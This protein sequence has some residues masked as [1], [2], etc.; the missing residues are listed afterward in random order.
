MRRQ[1][2]WFNFFKVSDSKNLPKEN[3]TL[4]LSQLDHLNALT[5]SVKNALSL[6]HLDKV[7]QCVNAVIRFGFD[8]LFEHGNKRL[9]QE[10]FRDDHF[11]QLAHI[12]LKNKLIT[13]VH[14]NALLQIQ[15]NDFPVLVS[16]FNCLDKQGA[17]RSDILDK[18]IML[19]SSALRH[20]ANTLLLLDSRL[21]TVSNVDR[22][23]RL[24]WLFTD[25]ANEAIWL[26]TGGLEADEF[27]EILNRVE[28]AEAANRTPSML[29]FCDENGAVYP[30]F[31]YFEKPRLTSAGKNAELLPD[32][33][34]VPAEL[35][36][37]L[38]CSIMTDPVR[39]KGQPSQHVFE[40]TWVMNW[41]LRNHTNPMTK[42][43]VPK[44]VELEPAA[45][46]LSKINVFMDEQVASQFS[47]SPSIRNDCV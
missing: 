35:T 46:I 34:D 22:L 6:L 18:V 1:F 32:S 38:S 10:R 30:S 41:I 42:L 12:L 36:C 8:G 21:V 29:D 16:I 14:V 20:F 37:P 7:D 2:S 31:V 13:L 11:S 39:I 9:L 47:L 33:I 15:S 44:N 27:H 43:P 45:D 3:L 23:L 4:V 19:E 40:K 5:E 28:S 17:M 24:S 26:R 25:T